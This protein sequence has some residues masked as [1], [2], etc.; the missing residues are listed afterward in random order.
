MIRSKMKVL[1][2]TPV[3][4]PL[5][6]PRIPRELTWDQIR[7]TTVKG[8]RLAIRKVIRIAMEHKVFY[9]CRHLC[10]VAVAITVVEYE[11]MLTEMWKRIC[12]IDDPWLAAVSVMY[13]WPMCFAVS[14]T[15]LKGFSINIRKETLFLSRMKWLLW[16]IKINRS[17]VPHRLSLFA[18]LLFIWLLRAIIIFWEQEY[19]FDC[20]VIVSAQ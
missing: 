13:S 6:P 3:P 5:L 14:W 15:K 8:R 12:W 17:C 19:V 7:G 10:H 20:N 4:L 16:S 9:I 1:G 11:C 2:E 18:L